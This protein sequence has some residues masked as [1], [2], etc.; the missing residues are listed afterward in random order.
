MHLLG[1]QPHYSHHHNSDASAA[2]GKQK[3]V[4]VCY[5]ESWEMQKQ[6]QGPE[7]AKGKRRNRKVAGRVEEWRI[8][9]KLIFE[10]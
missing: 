10:G 2:D 4:Q 5:V 7:K 9:G 8:S 6:C 1:P 3:G